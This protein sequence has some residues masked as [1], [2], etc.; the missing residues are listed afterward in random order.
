VADW[1][2]EVIVKVEP[3][4]DVETVSVCDSTPVSVLHHGRGGHGL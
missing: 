1:P 2:K 3:R 4:E